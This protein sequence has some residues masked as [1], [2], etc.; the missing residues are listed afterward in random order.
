MQNI[1]FLLCTKN[2]AGTIKRAI[3]S[4]LSTAI[5]GDEILVCDDSG[6]NTL[7]VIASF[8]SPIIRVIKGN[9]AGIYASRIVLISQARCPF[10]FFADGDDY[11]I[12]SAFSLMRQRL[13][14]F[15]DMLIFDC[16]K[17]KDDGPLEPYV[18]L[19]NTAYG[20]IA[21]KSFILNFLEGQ[22]CNPLWCKI[23]RRSRLNS[24]VPST[25]IS[26]LQGGE[27]RDLLIQ[28][29]DNLNSIFYS[30]ERAYVYSFNESGL[31]SVVKEH[32]IDDNLIYIEETVEYF[33]THRNLFSDS[34]ANDCVLKGSCRD[35]LFYAVSVAYSLPI[36]RSKFLLL[37]EH[38]LQS[39]AYQLMANKP[40]FRW[41]NWKRTLIFKAF[42]FKLYNPIKIFYQKRPFR[43]EKS[44]S[45]N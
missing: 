39:S 20:D 29:L 35:R 26:T 33:K 1:S 27:D 23:L 13:N 4:I 28:S 36:S 32:H 6:D 37:R 42:K 11:I 22:N 30:K 21:P 7:D 12:G 15:I 2:S 3:Q 25:L 5:D 17:T 24:N 19:P 16:Y 38:I 41:K 45:K 10:I 18:S 9:G 8:D 34:E 43:H 40:E 14:D 44:R 31:S